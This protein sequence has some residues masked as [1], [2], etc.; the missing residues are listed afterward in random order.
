MEK[1]KIVVCFPKHRDTTYLLDTKSIHFDDD[2]SYTKKREKI[3]FV[4]YEE[5]I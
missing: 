5:R 2:R 1:G 3:I 4:A